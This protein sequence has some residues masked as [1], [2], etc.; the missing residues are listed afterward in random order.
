MVSEK[1]AWSL[2]P[3]LLFGHR[4]VARFHICVGLSGNLKGWCAGHQVCLICS[5]AHLGVFEI[6]ICGL[7]QKPSHVFVFFC[8][9]WVIA[10]SVSCSPCSITNCGCLLSIF[11]KSLSLPEGRKLIMSAQPESW[12]CRLSQNH[13]VRRAVEKKHGTRGCGPFL[14]LP[15]GARKL[16]RGSCMLLLNECLCFFA[17]LMRGAEAT[18]KMPRLDGA[19]AF[20]QW[21]FVLRTV[22]TSA[23]ILG[24][25]ACLR[26][27]KC[28]SPA[29][30]FVLQAASHW[31]GGL[32]QSTGA[33]LSA[34]ATSYHCRLGREGSSGFYS[35]C[36]WFGG[37]KEREKRIK[38]KKKHPAHVKWH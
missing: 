19:Q 12:Y 28:H 18:L 10:T 35:W 20:T 38:K 21:P 8:Q 17:G 7:K 11:Q 32:T 23:N 5:W 27:P 31:E 14:S 15:S 25:P 22:C 13:P 2:A 34:A 16:W 37:K 33:R 29:F 30:K 1:S 26:A 9:A 4:A 36:F 3:S 6:Y 24:L